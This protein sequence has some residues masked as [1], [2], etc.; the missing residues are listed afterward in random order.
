MSQEEP[1]IQILRKSVGQTKPVGG[2]TI[3]GQ[4]GP[5]PLQRETEGPRQNQHHLSASCR[6]APLPKPLL[7]H[8]LMPPLMYSPQ[9]PAAQRGQTK[10]PGAHTGS[11][12]G[13]Q[14]QMQLRP[15]GLPT[16]GLFRPSGTAL[17]S[18]RQEPG[19]A[20]SGSPLLSHTPI[21][22]PVSSRLLIGWDRE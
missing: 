14:A 11:W 8:L 22:K 19:P 4:P 15:E 20:D 21:Q 6:S 16:H 3:H 1:K 12:H 5:L 13:I 7:Q 18:L 17:P 9:H 10:I 2:P